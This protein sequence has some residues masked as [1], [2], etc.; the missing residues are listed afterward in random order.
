MATTAEVKGGKLIITTDLDEQGVRSASGK[1]MVHAST[2]GNQTTSCMVNGK[3]LV[4]GL[5]A[6]TK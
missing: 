6:Y 2:H 4:I 3:P 5:N 1:T